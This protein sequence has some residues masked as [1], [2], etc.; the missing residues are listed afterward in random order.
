MYRRVVSLLLLPCVLL[1]QSAAA[2][3]HSHC[4]RLPGRNDLRPHFH[5]SPAPG[6][7]CHQHDDSGGS[8]HRHGPGDDLPEP[9]TPTPQPE[10]LSQDEHDSDA[11]YLDRV[12][13][14]LGARAAPSEQLVASLLLDAVALHVPISFCA[15]PPQEA[16]S[17]THAPPPSSYACPLYLWQLTLL[18]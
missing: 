7:H 3:A 12:D 11:V 2:L 18:I 14:V 9:G 17:W 4:P 8:G 16:V 10:P 13:V 15:D 6:G 5:T 1:T